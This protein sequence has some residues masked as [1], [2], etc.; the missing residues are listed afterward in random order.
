MTTDGVLQQQQKRSPT[1]LKAHHS[2]IAAEVVPNERAEQQGEDGR[3][4]RAFPSESHLF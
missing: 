2:S 1:I 4:N 3:A